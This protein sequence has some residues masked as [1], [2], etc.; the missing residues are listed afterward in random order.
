M[1]GIAPSASIIH[2]HSSIS[3]TPVISRETQFHHPFQAYHPVIL[4]EAKRREIC[5]RIEQISPIVEM[6][7][8]SGNS[9]F[10]I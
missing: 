4:R 7:E 9:S 1:F 10:L 2:C 5:K 3:I 6:T 8:E